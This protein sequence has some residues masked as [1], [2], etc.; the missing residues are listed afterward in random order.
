MSSSRNKVAQ[1]VSEWSRVGEDGE[2][3]HGEKVEKW[4]KPRPSNLS[5][6]TSHIHAKFQGLSSDDG[7][8]F[9]AFVRRRD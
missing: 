2:P 3:T 8:K 5:N 1:N 6:Y 9:C 7:V 4:I